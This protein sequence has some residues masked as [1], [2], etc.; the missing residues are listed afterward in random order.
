MSKHKPLPNACSEYGCAMGRRNTIEE[1]EA[2][3]KFHLRRMKLYDYGCYDEGGAYWGSGDPMYYA[4]GDGPKFVNEMFI[5][6]K[7]RQDAKNQVLAEFEHATF[8]Q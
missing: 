8:F 2:L 3:I 7:D 6:A 5:R 1:P 4:Y